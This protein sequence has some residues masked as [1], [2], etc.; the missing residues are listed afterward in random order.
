MKKGELEN[1][2]SG[3][4]YKKDRGHYHK[5][6]IRYKM[7]KT[8]VRIERKLSSGWF[9]LFSYYYKDIEINPETQKIRKRKK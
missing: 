6:D 9:K 1:F 8:S 4:G 7:Q 5:G 3:K 2:L